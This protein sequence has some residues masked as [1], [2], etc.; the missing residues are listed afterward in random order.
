MAHRIIPITSPKIIPYTGILG[1]GKILIFI[2]AV[3]ACIIF[4]RKH[5]KWSGI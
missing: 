5:Q 1:L 3:G 4:Y 2:S